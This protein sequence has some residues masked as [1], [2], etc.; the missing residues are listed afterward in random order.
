MIKKLRIGLATALA[1]LT[2]FTFLLFHAI[3]F[4]ML[5]PIVVIA[6]AIYPDEV[7]LTFRVKRDLREFARLT[8]VEFL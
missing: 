5:A 2:G 4:L 1:A 3:A 8:F 6:S 7:P